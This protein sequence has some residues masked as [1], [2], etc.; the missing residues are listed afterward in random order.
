MAAL[1][2]QTTFHPGLHMIN[3]AATVYPVVNF[4]CVPLAFPDKYDCS[5]GKCS[6]LSFL[7]H[8]FW[9]FQPPQVWADFA[10]TFCIIAAESSWDESA[11]KWYSGKA[12]VSC[13]RPEL[14][15]QDYALSLNQFMKLTIQADHLLRSQHPCISC[16]LLSAHHHRHWVHGNHSSQT[17]TWREGMLLKV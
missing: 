9:C 1:W 10:P 11:L 7:P 2:G 13:S 17:L 6:V 12:S 16:H 8:K 3:M 14:P 4:Q 5:L 15:C